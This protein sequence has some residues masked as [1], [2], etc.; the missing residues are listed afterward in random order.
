MS[1][2]AMKQFFEKAAAAPV[3]AEKLA[4][5]QKQYMEQMIV[6]AREN[7]VELA[8]GDFMEDI[9]ELS[10]DEAAKMVSG[11]FPSMSVWMG[12]F[13]RGKQNGGNGMFI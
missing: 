9:Q 7:G 12:E 2:E 4:A 6:L 5:V 1:K 10:D 3:L 13:Y 11:G 8:V